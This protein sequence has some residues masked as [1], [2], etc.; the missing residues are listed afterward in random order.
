MELVLVIFYLGDGGG[1]PL[2]RHYGLC[3]L[4]TMRIRVLITLRKDFTTF[5]T[6][7]TVEINTVRYKCNTNPNPN[8]NP[9]RHDQPSV[10]ISLF[11]SYTLSFNHS[12]RCV[13]SST[14]PQPNQ[15]FNI[16]VFVIGLLQ[17]ELQCQSLINLPR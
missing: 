4:H 13:M 1:S 16:V 7:H 3:S 14:E 6:L 9:I 10:R 8:P 2:V 15:T 5:S 11:V 12:V 17:H